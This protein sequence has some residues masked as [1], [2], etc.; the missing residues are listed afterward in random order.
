MRI[1]QLMHQVST[2]PRQSLGRAVGP[3][4][5]LTCLSACGSAEVEQPAPPPVDPR[6]YKPQAA[7]VAGPQQSPADRN[8]QAADAFGRALG[9]ND[10]KSL[11]ELLDPD[12][13]FTFPGKADATDRAGTLKALDDLL[14]T[15][16]ARTYAP[17]R[18]WQIGE[19]VVV[20]WVMKGTQSSP[21]MGVAPT[22]KEVTVRGVTLQWFNLNGLINEVH[23]YFDCG[24]V[25]AQLGAAPNKAIE[26]GPPGTLSP[27]PVVTVA[28]GSADEKANVAIVNASW[29][30]LEAK[31]EAGYMAPMA[32]GVEVVRADHSAAEKGKAERTK[33]FRWVVT[34]VSSLTQTPLNAWGAGSF[35]IEEYTLTGVHSGK[36]TPFPP[37]GHAL[38]LHYLDIDEMQNGKIIRTSTYGNVLELYAESGAIPN[39]A[40]G[41]S[42][43]ASPASSPLAAAAH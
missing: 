38:R 31:N 26:A 10:Q 6:V 3:A 18:V 40:P 33:F 12:V 1:R 16:S 27:S 34:G 39:A 15:F 25:L 36:L 19:A 41:P 23:V 11:S 35:V 22:Q 5:L 9:K 37:S 2:T 4:L 20:E 29:D 30:A 8:R 21:W 14:G 24:S 32:D 7:Q 42:S 28:T 13:D 17:S 43:A